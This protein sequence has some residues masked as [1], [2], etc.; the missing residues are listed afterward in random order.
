MNKFALIA[1]CGI[2]L[3]GCAA[4]NRGARVDGTASS[5]AGGTSGATTAP[6]GRED[7]RNSQDTAPA[8]EGDRRRPSGSAPASKY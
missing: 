4:D 3:A 7:M 5:S 8:A 1:L 2:A 6:A